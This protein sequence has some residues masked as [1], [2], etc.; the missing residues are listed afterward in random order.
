[1]SWYE[2]CILSSA[3]SNATFTTTDAKLYIPIV[4]LSTEDNVKLS[5]QLGEELKK[6]FIGINTK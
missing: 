3:G 2:N 1:M 6:Q 5:K 4:T